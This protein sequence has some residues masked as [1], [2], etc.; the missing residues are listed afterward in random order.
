MDT[1]NGLEID[2]IDVNGNYEPN[3]CRFVTRLENSRNKRTTL[4]YQYNGKEMTLKEIADLEGIKYKT[5]WQRINRDNL[6][7]QQAVK[8]NGNK[9]I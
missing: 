2:R 3:N 1:K 6:S 9:G 5:L 4:K 8:R 7:L